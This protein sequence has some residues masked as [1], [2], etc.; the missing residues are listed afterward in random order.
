LAVGRK[1]AFPFL[2]SAILVL[3]DIFLIV[4]LSGAMFDSKES[5]YRRIILFLLVKILLL[6]VGLYGILYFFKSESLYVFVGLSLPIA[7]FTL[8]GF[9]ERSS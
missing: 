5:G 2:L 8:F 6:T 4:E 1:S 9:F 3:I 7:V